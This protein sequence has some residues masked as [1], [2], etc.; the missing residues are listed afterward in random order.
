MEGT[1]V[2]KLAAL[3][4]R[5]WWYAERRA[6]LA[7]AL[8]RVPGTPGTALD[9]GAAGGGNT[10]VLRAAGWRSLALEYGEDGAA[11]AHERGLDVVRGDATRLPVADA[12]IGLVVAFDVLEHIPDD[13]AALREL[14]RVLRPGGTLLV[15]VPAGMRNWSA[16]DVAVGHVRRY[17]RE[18]LRD[19]VAGGGFEL[20]ELRSWNVLMA[21]VARW[22][23]RSSTGSDLDDPHPALNAACRAV[24]VAER[25]L[26]VGGLPG[27]SLLATAVRR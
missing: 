18:G 5:H 9:V 17:E 13:A 27:I 25:V 7:A 26:P 21:P 3:E 22:R 11:V 20:R 14:H 12:S 19:L 24:V 6:L 8:R 16:H 15:A 23:R 1:E 4:D 2:R 10:R